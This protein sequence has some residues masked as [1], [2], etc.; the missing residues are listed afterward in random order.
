MEVCL[1]EAVV[2]EVGGGGWSKG[3]WV[4]RGVG[5]LDGVTGDVMDRLWCGCESRM[6]F[7]EE[8]RV[9]WAFLLAACV[10]SGSLVQWMALCFGPRIPTVARRHGAS[11]LLKHFKHIL[12]HPQPSRYRSTL[13][14]ELKMA[15]PLPSI[16][17][18]SL[19]FPSRIDQYHY[20]P[21]SYLPSCNHRGVAL[22]DPAHSWHRMAC[23]PLFIAH[24]TTAARYKSRLPQSPSK[25]TPFSFFH[26]KK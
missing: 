6:D 14:R 18:F 2:R 26:H 25:Q 24:A 5:C 4:M 20:S 16:S 21:D 15:S 3:L 13:D 17:R 7:G 8:G 22:F 9:G 1:E 12:S 23:S 10:W 19:T 11:L